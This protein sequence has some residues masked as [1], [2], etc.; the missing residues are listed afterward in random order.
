[1]TK[2]RTSGSTAVFERM[3]ARRG[4]ARYVLRLYV[5]GATARSARAIAQIK[6]I[7][8]ENLA[9]RYD[10]EVI[11]LYQQPVLA[12]GDQIIATPTLVKKLPAPLRKF[13]GDFSNAERML[14]GLDLKPKHDRRVKRAP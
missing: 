9:G 14:V 8:E 7:C 1:M 2:K 13:I 12:Q 11:D 6:S 3:A 5:A 4:A 10:L